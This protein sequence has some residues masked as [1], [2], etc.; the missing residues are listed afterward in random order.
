MPL[1][2]SYGTLQKADVQLATFGRL[3]FGQP[4]YL[5]G[6]EPSLVATVGQVTHANASF[7]G[8]S[9]SRVSGTAFEVTEAELLAADKYERTAS[10]TRIA[11]ALGSGAQ[12]WVYVD[13]RSLGVVQG[14]VPEDALL[15]TYRGGRHPELWGNYGDC[16]S[17]PI[18]QVVSLSEFVY[19]FYT[20]PVF[21][22]ERLI[23]RWLVN[24]PSS[25]QE[26][27]QLADGTRDNFAAWR[28]GERSETQLLM[29]DR[30]ERTRSWFR[31]TAVA[32]GAGSRTLLQFGSAIVARRGRQ[33]GSVSMSLGFRLML[34]FHQQYSRALLRAA[35]NKLRGVR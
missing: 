8:R 11:V 35:A 18:A 5:P 16:F 27:R 20:S 32:A 24:A 13:A 6:F 34:G 28:V 25:D 9:N 30:Y 19:R 7:N 31:V 14:S 3:V 33:P 2:F 12:A 17:I 22:L 1:L 10:Y 26:A 29:C 23:L 4:D 15:K 21:K